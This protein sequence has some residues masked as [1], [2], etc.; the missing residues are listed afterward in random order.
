MLN[1][2]VNKVLLASALALTLVNPISVFAS[3]DNSGK[4]SSAQANSMENNEGP[5]VSAEQENATNFSSNES[6]SSLKKYVQVEN[7]QYV[8]SIPSGVS[9]DQ[10]SLNFIQ[11]SIE[12]ANNLVQQKDIKINPVSKTGTVVSQNAQSPMLAPASDLEEHQVI[13]QWFGV[14]HLFRSNAALHQF[15]DTLNVSAAAEAGISSADSAVTAVATATGLA[16]EAILTAAGAAGSGV[17]GAD[18]AAMS[19][20]INGFND[21]HADQKVGVNIMFG[22]TWHNFTFT[23]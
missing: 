4:D 2:R 22:L 12:E 18:L 1:K 8:L 17:Y 3:Q 9:L 10:K 21:A 20:S 19:A 6:L 13:Y 14:T 23:D 5:V 15:T 16:P 11:K 7:N